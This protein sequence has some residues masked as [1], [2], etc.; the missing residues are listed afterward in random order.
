MSQ[1]N[2]VGASR[3]TFSRRIRGGIGKTCRGRL[4]GAIR[5][6]VESL[7]TRRL[8]SANVVYVNAA[9]AGSTNGSDPGSL[10]GGNS[11]GYDEFATIQ[12]GIGAVASGGTVIIDNGNYTA[13]N[14]VVS[15]AM[16][17]E[18]ESESGVVISPS[19]SDSHDDSA[20]GGSVSNGFVI[21]A[22]GVTIEDLTLDGGANQDYR[23]GVIT[24]SA[25]DGNTYDDT[26]VANVTM[27]NI[28]RQ[29]VALYNFT[30]ESTGNVVENNTFNN[31]GSVIDDSGNAYQVTAAVGMFQSD[32]TVQGNNITNSAAGVVGT[33]FD[34]S[35][36][37]LSVT[38]NS[39]TSAAT[40]LNGALG[41]D[42]QY[43]AAGSSVT[44]NTIDL[45][46][47][48]TA[49][50]DDA[51]VVGMDQGTV[52]I[53]DNTITGQ[54]NDNGIVLFNDGSNVTL[55]GNSMQT[56][57]Y[58][59]DNGTGI[60]LTD[61]SSDTSQFGAAP[62][63]ISATLTNDIVVLYNYGIWLNSSGDPVLATIGDPNNSANS[64]SIFA[65]E[66][67]I[68]VDGSG[69]VATITNN[70]AI[71]QTDIGADIYGCVLGIGINGGTAN[72]DNNL[73]LENQ[74]TI[75]VVSGTAN[76][77]GNTFLSNEQVIEVDSG[78]MT[79]DNNLFDSNFGDSIYVPDNGNIPSVTAYDNGFYVTPGFLA[80]DDQ[81]PLVF[82]D[83]RENYWGSDHMTDAD[84]QDVVYGS[85]DF[86]PWLDTGT[87]TDQFTI[88]NPTGFTGNFSALDV[89][90]ESTQIGS[91]TALQLAVNTL[92]PG[93]VITLNDGTYD[94]NLDITEP[95][96]I[97]SAD[98]AGS[99]IIAD[100]PGTGGAIT[101]E[102]GVDGVTISGLT[103]QANTNPWALDILGSNATITGNV[104]ESSGAGNVQTADDTDTITGNTFIAPSPSAET[105][106]EQYNDTAPGYDSS[107][108]ITGLL[109]NNTFNREDTVQISSGVYVRTIY[110]DPPPVNATPTISLNPVNITYGT[111][112]A[113]GQL[114]GTAS[115]IVGGNTVDVA[116]TFVYT[117]AAGTVLGAGS[118]QSEAVTFTPT[119]T[120]DYT[121][122]S[123]L[124]T[125]NVASATPTITVKRVS[126]TYGT[127]LA[128]GQ[129][130]GT[131]SFIVGG[132]TVAVAGTFAYTSA[133]GTVLGAGSSQSEA[134]TFT[135]TD[136]TDYTTASGSVTVNVA[137]AK[138]TITVNPV[139]ITYG[140]ALANGQLSG[141]ASFIVG[142]STVAVA[143]TFAYTSA[144]GAVLGA[145]SVHTKAVT[146][147]PTDTTDYTT[148]SGSVTVNVAQATPTITVNPVNITYGTALAKGQL[149]GTASFIVGGSTVAVAGT[150]TYTSATGTVLGT[151]SGQS[152]AVTFTPNDS[153]NYT[154]V[155]GSVTVNVAQAT[156]TISVTHV[157]ITYG[158]ALANG[159]LNGTASF[160]VGGSTVA[161]AGTFTYTSAAGTVLG[162]G[163][164]Q[165]EAVTFT[166]TDT[167]DYTTA[168]G[169]VTV[170]VAQAKPT[171][172]VN[173]VNIIYGTALANGQLSGTASYI[174]GSSTVAVAGTFAYTSAAGAVLGAGSHTKAVT[175]TPTDTTDYTTAS[176]SVTVNVA[177]ATPTITASAGATVVVGTGVKLTASALLAGG[178]GVTGK[179][180]FTLYG[181]SGLVVNTETA[182]VTGDGTYVTPSGYLPTVAGTYQWVVSYGGDAN[183]SLATTVNGAT[184]EIAMA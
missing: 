42:L 151:G 53:D 12:D 62:G 109:A 80:V 83:A 176:G 150:F 89:G 94:T 106:F 156:P 121:D 79:A 29:G 165:S 39:F 72:I 18:G 139:N 56:D 162:A 167:T 125:V 97:D 105:G 98:G 101:I 4:A 170:N 131:A 88:I 111:A 26:V 73:I 43:L 130:S 181:P 172:T 143:G 173:P 71:S 132:N 65:D 95:L 171:I 149:S 168:S 160:K 44:G 31:V 164:G 59:F 140:T 3:S 161:V 2:F 35:S 66:T 147:T 85:V 115:L 99:T 54:D 22:S 37:T 104:F 76:I 137:K 69:S 45:T 78:S 51:I 96:T 60:L 61:Q 70:A 27:N 102:A 48:G 93:G 74:D 155:S 183:N 34:G 112:L 41:I 5:P 133:A 91:V 63:A 126:I 33:T 6:V 68:E 16:T 36:Q 17:I 58:N 84:V 57:D 82:A 86:S 141:T 103:I 174:V 116:G 179:I 144:A 182:S 14:I 154:T 67:G 13:S 146:F 145:G 175:F 118:G 148:A 123:G 50:N 55:D 20:F 23:A 108:E 114:S 92:S 163:S 25:N 11:F 75:Q 138:P 10:G 49:G 38:S 87:P 128:N 81:N 120:T 15:Q 142:G 180:T 153:T 117:T 135:P 157:N 178:Y 7:E 122:A 8:L 127:A 110:A 47:T 158:T 9:W 177:Q 19:G 119:D 28:F 129:L 169:S 159:Q 30:G 152:E 124:V 77:D 136:T 64:N 113:N 32:G 24:N 1:R 184:P 52:S 134:V 107:G 90:P 46:G 166:P 100:P 21:A 40:V